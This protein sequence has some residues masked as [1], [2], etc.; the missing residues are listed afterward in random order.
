MS[1]ETAL[2]LM[3][4]CRLSIDGSVHPIILFEQSTEAYHWIRD[5]PFDSVVKRRYPL[6]VSVSCEP[7]YPMW[8]ECGTLRRL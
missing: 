4:E 2:Q 7:I 5:A 6:P 3:R 8:K 1:R